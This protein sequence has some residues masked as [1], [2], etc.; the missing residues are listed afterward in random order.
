MD[1]TELR[2]M[3]P[4]EAHATKQG[5]ARQEKMQLREQA[6]DQGKAAN[7]THQ[8]RERGTNVMKLDCRDL[9]MINIYTSCL[10]IPV[11]QQYGTVQ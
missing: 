3:S 7:G 4:I 9:T 10:L 2:E 11:P 6:R 5:I 8:I 1:L